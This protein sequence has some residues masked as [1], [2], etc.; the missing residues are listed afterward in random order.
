M[1]DVVTRGFPLGQKKTSA[2]SRW[3]VLALLVAGLAAVLLTA[4]W[5]TAAPLSSFLFVAFAALVGVG[6]VWSS[7]SANDTGER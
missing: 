4:A 6:A 5:I 7:M 2:T 3:L 1:S